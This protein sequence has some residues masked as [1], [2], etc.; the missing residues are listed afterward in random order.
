VAPSDSVT[1]PQITDY[2][3]FHTTSTHALFLQD[4]VSLR[5]TLDGKNPEGWYP[6]QRVPL[7]A[8]LMGYTREAA[9][10]SFREDSL[11]QIA[12]G[13]LADLTVIDR[14][15]FAIDREKLGVRAARGWRTGCAGA[16]L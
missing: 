8:A 7:P 4:I 12:P 2:I 14:D 1:D 13:F 3:L 9:Y 15:L 6:E 5:E 16:I 11:G 10:A